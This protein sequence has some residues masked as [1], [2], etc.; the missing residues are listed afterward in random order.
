MAPLKSSELDMEL[1]NFE[2]DSKENYFY[3]PTCR[4]SIKVS[5]R[6]NQICRLLNNEKQEEKEITR[7]HFMFKIKQSSEICEI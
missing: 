6:F 3:L 4:K 1:N 7:K 5:Y 2:N